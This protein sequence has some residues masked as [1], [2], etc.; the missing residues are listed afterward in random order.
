MTVKIDI[1]SEIAVY[2]Q[3]VDALRP[4]LVEG[5]F[6]PGDTLP[7]IRQLAADLGVHFNTVA[8]AYRILASEGWLEL[9]R[10]RGAVVL[11]RE[12]PKPDSAAAKNFAKRLKEMVAE[13]QSSGLRSITIVEE[14]R[15]VAEKLEA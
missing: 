3:I 15:K 12:T 9:R 7:S 1:N 5:L 2:K 6:A 14:L 10:K 8:E 4:M 13:V 11:S